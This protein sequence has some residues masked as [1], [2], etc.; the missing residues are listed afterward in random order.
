MKGLL[1]YCKDPG[2]GGCGGIVARYRS[3]CIVVEGRKFHVHS[4]EELSSGP[5]DPRFSTRKITVEP[6][7]GKCIRVSILPDR[8]RSEVV[9]QIKNLKL[10][11]IE[12]KFPEEIAQICRN[13]IYER[14]PKN[15]PSSLSFFSRIR[16]YLLYRLLMI[17]LKK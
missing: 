4:H 5:H 17:E 8:V 12:Q 7:N 11:E 13:I 10:P 6:C 15:E 16:H 9:D 1:F 2:S 14:N 3:W